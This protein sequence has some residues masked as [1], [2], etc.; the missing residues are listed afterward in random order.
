MVLANVADVVDRGRHHKCRER[1][2]AHMA[3]LARGIA[4]RLIAVLFRAKAAGRNRVV[5][6]TGRDDRL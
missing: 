1:K 5:L 3:L 2:A 4:A 6:A